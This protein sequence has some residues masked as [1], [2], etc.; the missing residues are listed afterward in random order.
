VPAA[1]IPLHNAGAEAALLA[2]PDFIEQDHP[3]A[4]FA[5]H[6]DAGDETKRQERIKIP[7]EG[8]KH[9]PR[10][11]QSQTREQRVLAADRVAEPANADTAD[12]RAS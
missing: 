9:R 2:P 8:G 5:A 11:E 4:P 12:D 10:G 1:D 3:G 6:A 7:G